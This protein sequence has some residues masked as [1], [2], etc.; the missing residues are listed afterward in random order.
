[1]KPKKRGK[2]IFCQNIFYINIF[3]HINI[4]SIYPK[5]TGSGSGLPEK[6]DLKKVIGI[7]R[8]D[9]N[10]SVVQLKMI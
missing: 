5:I 6:R 7:I 4:P 1:M 8:W 3:K 10:K 9:L 2:L